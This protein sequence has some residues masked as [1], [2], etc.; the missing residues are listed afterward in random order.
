MAI[1]SLLYLEK[2]EFEHVHDLSRLFCALHA[3]TQSEVRAKHEAYLQTNPAGFSQTTEQGIKTDLDSLL[4]SGKD[5]FEK[6][7]YAF[8]KG[9]AN[10]NFGLEAVLQGIRDRLLEKHPEWEEKIP[11]GK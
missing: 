3:S 5:A 6:C 2:R 8:Q 1:I 9:N 7:R 4:E 11:R 10:T